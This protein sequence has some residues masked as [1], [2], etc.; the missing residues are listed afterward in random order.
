MAAISRS[1]RRRRRYLGTPIISTNVSPRETPRIESAD[2]SVS[3]TS[4]LEASQE[5]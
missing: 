4:L 1:V 5:L 2:L 3:V